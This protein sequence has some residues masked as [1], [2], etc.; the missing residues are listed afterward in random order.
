MKLFVTILV[1]SV[2]SGWITMFI[3][4]FFIRK[5]NSEKTIETN[6]LP[7]RIKDINETIF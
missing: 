3:L 2:I 5:K 6:D 7:D 4:F 1:I